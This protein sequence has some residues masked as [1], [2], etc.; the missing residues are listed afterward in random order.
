MDR[1][2]AWDPAGQDAVPEELLTSYLTLGKHVTS[3]GPTLLVC[4]MG[5]SYTNTMFSNF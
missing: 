5:N 4:K 1:A 3:W 2:Q